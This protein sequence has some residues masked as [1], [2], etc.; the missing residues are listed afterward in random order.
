MMVQNGIYTYGC[1][2]HVPGFLLVVEGGRRRLGAT[3]SKVFNETYGPIS[4]V[5]DPVRHH[6]VVE[7]G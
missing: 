4:K 7:P 3:V 5:L 6:T 1:R 2:L